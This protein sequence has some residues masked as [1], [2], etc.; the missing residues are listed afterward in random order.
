MLIL[1][2]GLEVLG[3]VVGTIK[4]LAEYKLNKYTQDLPRVRCRVDDLVTFLDI[5]VVFVGIRPEALCIISVS[6][7]RL[8]VRS[9]RNLSLGNI[10]VRVWP[11][12]LGVLGMAVCRW[13]TI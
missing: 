2:P 11:W 3:Q 1:S 7:D 4:R 8:A 6:N 12:A 9:V 13:A 5:F 10:S